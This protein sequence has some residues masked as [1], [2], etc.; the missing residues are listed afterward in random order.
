MLFSM[1][2]GPSQAQPQ[3]GAFPSRVV[4]ERHPPDRG[5]PRFEQAG[6]QPDDHGLQL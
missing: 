5:L 1:V 4:T 6:L 3:M 2:P